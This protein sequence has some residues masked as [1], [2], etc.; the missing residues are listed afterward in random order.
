MWSSSTTK[1][2]ELVAFYMSTDQKRLQAGTRLLTRVH[3]ILPLHL[4]LSLPNN[5]YAHVPITSISTTLT[6]QLA[7][8]ESSD[9][10]SNASDSEVPDLADL[11]VPGQYLVAQVE[12]LFPTASN[13]LMQQYQY[14]ETLRLAGRVECTLVPEVVNADVS[15]AD[16]EV[17]EW[18]KGTEVQYGFKI[19]AEVLGEEDRGWR[20]GLGVEGL[21]GFVANEEVAKFAQG[22]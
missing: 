3:Q 20:V 22:V 7:A 15:K 4:L 21:E 18:K 6:T 17:K 11:F 8:E 10:A 16:L 12:K 19:Q 1:F 14:S 9:V 13:E 2:V 5:L